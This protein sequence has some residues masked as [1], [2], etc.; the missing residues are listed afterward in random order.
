MNCGQGNSG[1]VVRPD[2]MQPAGSVPERRD[3]PAAFIIGVVMNLCS[4]CGAITL[5]VV[6]DACMDVLDVLI[7]EADQA[8]ERSEEDVKPTN[9]RDD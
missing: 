6:C 4:R 1:G 3:Q 9:S 5:H 2:R 8:Q 7:E